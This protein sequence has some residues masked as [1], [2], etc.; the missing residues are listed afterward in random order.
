MNNNVIKLEEK[1]IIK[2][3]INIKGE[4]YMIIKI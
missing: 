3:I 1:V 2:I 4:M